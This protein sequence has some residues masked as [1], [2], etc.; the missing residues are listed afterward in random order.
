MNNEKASVGIS[1][2][3]E[4]RSRLARQIG[5][6]LASEWLQNRESARANRRDNRSAAQI[7]ESTQSDSAG[8]S[9]FGDDRQLM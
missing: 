8:A 4:A 1:E 7:V 2:R 3:E 5:R 9:A 6:I